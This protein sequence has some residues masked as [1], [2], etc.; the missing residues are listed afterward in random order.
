[1]PK[2]MTMALMSSALPELA[3]VT[4]QSF[5]GGYASRAFINQRWPFWKQAT[6]TVK[7]NDLEFQRNTR[8]RTVSVFRDLRKQ[9]MLALPPQHRKKVSVKAYR[10]ISFGGG[11]VVKWRVDPLVVVEC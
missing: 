8:D 7:V 4:R 5:A 3:S 9:I 10:D 6:G 2:D 1:M 11:V